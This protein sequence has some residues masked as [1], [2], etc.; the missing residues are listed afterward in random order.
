MWFFHSFRGR[1]AIQKRGRYR[2]WR[3]CERAVM[4]LAACL[5]WML[6]PLS[7]DAASYF[8]K[9]SSF[10]Y[11]SMSWLYR[12]CSLFKDCLSSILPPRCC[13]LCSSHFNAELV[14]SLEKV[15]HQVLYELLHL[16]EF[17]LIVHS[18]GLHPA[19]KFCGLFLIY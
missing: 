12:G 6:C 15:C 9:Y 8:L 5:V 17:S 4:S 10:L 18:L 14:S 3:T 2:G 1:K 11:I 7:T 19:S 13:V 16:S